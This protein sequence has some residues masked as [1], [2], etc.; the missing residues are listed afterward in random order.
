MPM[1]G[2]RQIPSLFRMT[3]ITEGGI[4][5]PAWSFAGQPALR[6]RPQPD[7]DSPS[8]EC[9]CGLAL[10]GHGDAYNEEAFRYLLDVE[11]NRF[12][13]S[14]RPFVLVLV[15]LEQRSGL[16]HRFDSALGAK[17]FA[18]LARSLRETDVI[19]WYREGRVVGALLTHL[20]DAPIADVSRQMAERVAQTL[21]DELPERVARR[22]KV[23]LYRPLARLRP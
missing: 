7:V 4:G 11:R 6:K 2:I 17:V 8:H 5:L 10:T 12:D 13:Y 3:A 22:L 18:S 16:P 1:I 20:G 21:R 15:D 9:S 14:S 23:R 19:G